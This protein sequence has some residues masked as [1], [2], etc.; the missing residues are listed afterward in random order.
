MAVLNETNRI[1]VARLGSDPA[2]RT[3]KAPVYSDPQR[4]GGHPIVS[5]LRT[6][7]AEQ[8][9][10]LR[11]LVTNESHYLDVR[12]RC[13]NETWVGARF[14]EPGSLERLELVIGLPCDQ[15]IFFWFDEGAPKNWGSV[16]APPV[17]LALAELVDRQ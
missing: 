8:V 5:D 10:Q 15:L 14:G 2:Q 4:I 16:V 1:A 13:K 7:S 6:L 3:Q 11:Q 9:A 12:R 17:G